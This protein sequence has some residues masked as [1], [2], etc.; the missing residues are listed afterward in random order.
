MVDLKG[1]NI[2]LAEAI[3]RA[4]RIKLLITD[5]DGVLTD[6]GVYFGPEGEVMKRFSIRDGMG[7]ERLRTECGVD[8]G[9]MTGENSPAV[10]K[11]AEKLKIVH[12]FPGIKDKRSLFGEIVSKGEFAADEIA[13][14]GDDYND[15]GIIDEAVF[16]ASP[17]DGM[18]YIRS[19]V[20]YVCSVNAGYGAYRDF[21]ELIIYL[22]GLSEE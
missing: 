19:L 1:L 17:A 16:T 12:Y 18:P 15:T 14:I 8:T 20:D 9:I 4:K 6:T 5:V 11:R 3:K 7:V 13:F 10:Q 22:R 2:P 21:A